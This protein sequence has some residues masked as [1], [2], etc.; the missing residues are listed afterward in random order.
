M[1]FLFWMLYFSCYFLYILSW[2][3]LFFRISSFLVNIVTMHLLFITVLDAKLNLKYSHLIFLSQKFLWFPLL[4]TNYSGCIPNL[5]DIWISVFCIL[6]FC[7]WVLQFHFVI[8]L[9]YHSLH[10]K[11][12]F[13]LYFCFCNIICK[14]ENKFYFLCSGFT[15]NKYINLKL[16]LDCLLS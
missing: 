11:I 9:F 8:I 5:W 4:P 7:H 14:L 15:H 1:F 3:I 2:N 10:G 12:S 16:V 13:F 6:P